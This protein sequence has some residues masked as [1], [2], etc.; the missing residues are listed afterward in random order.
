[1]EIGKYLIN[2]DNYDYIEFDNGPPFYITFKKS[3][4]YVSANNEGYVG[5]ATIPIQVKTE[6]EWLKIKQQILNNKNEKAE[7]AEKKLRK[8]VKKLEQDLKY[9]AGGKEYLEAKDDFFEKAKN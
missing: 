7:K 3:L 4:N 5:E 6:E 8:K 1:M 9:I 2:L